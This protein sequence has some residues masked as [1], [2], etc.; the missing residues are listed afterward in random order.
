MPSPFADEFLGYWYAALDEEIGILLRIIPKERQ[1]I[2][3]IL[4]EGRQRAAD[5]ELDA[6][7]IIVPKEDTLYIAKKAT[8]LVE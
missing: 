5:P 3:N 6:L 2:M 4:Y 7:M 1:K 8:E